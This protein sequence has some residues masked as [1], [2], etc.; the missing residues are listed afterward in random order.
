MKLGRPQR[1]FGRD[2]IKTAEIMDKDDGEPSCNFPS[3]SVNK[4]AFKIRKSPLAAFKN[5]LTS[6]QSSNADLKKRDSSKLSTETTNP[7]NSNALEEGEVVRKEIAVKREEKNDDGD[8]D[9]V[10]VEQDKEPLVPA[11]PQRRSLMPKNLF[12]PP[13]EVTI[14]P[15]AVPPSPMRDPALPLM[16][17]KAS[18]HPQQ[19]QPPPYPELLMTLGTSDTEQPYVL[20]DPLGD[21]AMKRQLLDAQRLVRLILGKPLCGDQQL[22]ETTTILQAIRAFA[23][24]KQELVDLRKKQEIADG[25]PPAILQTLGSPVGTTPT[26]FA[27]GLETPTSVFFP[28]NGQEEELS[29][30]TLRLQSEALKEANAK[31]ESLQQQLADANERICKIQQEKDIPEPAFPEPAV[32][33]CHQEACCK[34]RQTID[35]KYHRL[36]KVHEAAVEESQRNMDAVIESVASVPKK[37]L[38][39]DSVREKLKAYCTAVTNHASQ[40]LRIEREEQMLREREESQRIIEELQAKLKAQEDS[41]DRQEEPVNASGE[42]LETRP[43]LHADAL[44]DPH[45]SVAL[46]F[47]EEKKADT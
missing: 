28:A 46:E 7:D 3:D 31:I 17:R 40:L 41:S 43:T 15:H 45:N 2:T 5:K 27:A 23:M 16:T 30:D 25:D 29:T 10:S 33:D 36:V 8:A 24:M 11:S 39:K 37:V 20:G 42:L 13:H 4:E 35:A 18:D 34:H 14:D 38:A 1:L 6:R 12:Q 21:I 32:E 9:T 19:Q 44:A 47:Q 26:S 22:L